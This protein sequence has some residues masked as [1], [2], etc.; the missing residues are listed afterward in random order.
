MSRQ[1]I[2]PEVQNNPI[3]TGIRSNA[4]NLCHRRPCRYPRARLTAPKTIAAAKI[5]S[6]ARLQRHARHLAAVDVV[7]RTAGRC[8]GTRRVARR[9]SDDDRRPGA[10]ACRALDHGV[11]RTSLRRARRRCRREYPFQASPRRRRVCFATSFRA[12]ATGIP[13]RVPNKRPPPFARRR[14]GVRG[15]QTAATAKATAPTTARRRR[16]GPPRLV[17]RYGGAAGDDEQHRGWPCRRPRARRASSRS[18]RRVA[19]HAAHAPASSSAVETRADGRPDAANW[20]RPRKAGRTPSKSA[21]VTYVAGAAG[22]QS[23]PAPSSAR[24]NGIPRL[25]KVV[26]LVS[27]RLASP[28]CTA[29]C[30][31]RTPAEL[32]EQLRRARGVGRRPA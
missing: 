3:A 20:S 27:Y 7:A 32:V 19:H 2:A 1:K 31:S 10:R 26:E 11:E 8:R 12:R 21:V 22:S 9:A 14:D 5:A 23:S 13:G 18:R 6:S 15:S 30:S 24:A 4:P 25:R 17:M 29:T 28:T 16:R